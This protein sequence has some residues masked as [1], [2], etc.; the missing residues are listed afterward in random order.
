LG[1]IIPATV[2]SADRSPRDS[3]RHATDA[4]H[5][6]LHEHREFAAL[7]RGDLSRTSYRR[8]LFGLLGL[9]APIEQRL[10][11]HDAHPW[12]AWRAAGGTPRSRR[13]RHD[14]AALGVDDAA[15]DAAPEAGALLPR[16]DDPAAAL[17]CAWVIEGSALGAKVMA[18][19]LDTML[20]ADAAACGTFFRA[21]PQQTQQ[22]R[23][24]CDSV[25]ACGADAARR[26][27]M[28]AAAE[29]TFDA[30]AVWLD[31]PRLDSIA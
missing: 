31:P 20:G 13:L 2:A 17:G 4:A 28:L 23:A 14:L 12:L 26:D 8:L 7:L 11:P 16:L 21:E 5:R 10:A 18:A 9:H 22:W 19:R 25:A 29:A 6:R 3:L 15:I 24:C 1:V 27:A 30:F